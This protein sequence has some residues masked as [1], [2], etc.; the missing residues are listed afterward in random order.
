MFSAQL[1]M[2][3]LAGARARTIA[4]SFTLL[5]VCGL[6]LVNSQFVKSV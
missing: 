3:D 6:K 4:A 5:Q 1:E 2:R